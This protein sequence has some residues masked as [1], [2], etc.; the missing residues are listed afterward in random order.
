[1][2][3]HALEV[4]EGYAWPGNVRELR[5][6]ME[7]F[8]IMSPNNRIDAFDLPEQILRRT[9]LASPGPDDAASLQDARDRFEREFILQKLAEYKGNVSRTAQALKIERSNLYRKM[10]QLGIPYSATIEREEV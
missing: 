6:T 9:M 2:T 8:I 1:M 10:R 7:R 4:L 3:R 5:N